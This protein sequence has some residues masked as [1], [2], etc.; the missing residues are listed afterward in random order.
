MKTAIIGVGAVGGYFGGL[1]ANVGKDITFVARGE[2]Y[3]ALLESGLT[4]NT[5][6]GNYHLKN[7]NLVDD[8]TKLECPDLILVC[9]KTYHLESVAKDIIKVVNK[10]TI[11]IPLCNGIDNDIFLKEKLP[12]CRVYPGLSY[13]I[14]SRTSPGVITQTAGACTIF[15]GERGVSDNPALKGIETFLKSAGIL[16]TYSSNIEFALWKKFIWLN[17]FAGMTALC[18]S[19]IGPIVNSEIGF[20]LLVHNKKFRVS[21]T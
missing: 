9:T 21:F 2:Q 16:A 1:L 4:L 10:E 12:E 3:Q 13:I 7:L 11:V 15:F 19:S 14:A 5:A 6:S 17:A 18:K 8:I 20:E